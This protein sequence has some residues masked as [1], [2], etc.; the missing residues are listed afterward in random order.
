M[1]TEQRTDVHLTISVV[2]HSKLKLV[3]NDVV[4]SFPISLLEALSG[5][6]KNVETISGFK[7][8][9]IK[10]KSRNNEEIIIPNLGVNK[11]GSQRV[12]LDV[13]YPDNIDELIEYLSKINST[14][15][16]V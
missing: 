9:T 2:P 12:I 15:Q 6:V 11:Q 1:N 5:C 10:P 7:E 13:S 3:G 4:L 16:E 14:T 8:I